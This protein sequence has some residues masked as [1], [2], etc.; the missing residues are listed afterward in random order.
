MEEKDFSILRIEA[1]NGDYPV[2]DHVPRGLS[3]VLY[4][5]AG[6]GR[7]G[8]RRYPPLLKRVERLLVP[9][10]GDTDHGFYL[11]HRQVVHDGRA[12]VLHLGAVGQQRVHCHLATK[13][14]S[15]GSSAAGR[16][17][18]RFRSRVSRAVERQTK[19]LD[20]KNGNMVKKKNGTR[21]G[22]SLQFAFKELQQ[23]YI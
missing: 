4:R 9:V 19:L 8:W 18:D 20:N 13:N 6:S 21:S 1:R 16:V 14:K 5:I 23:P 17:I 2:K 10:E 22:R 11:L 3:D 12:A 15:T 7:T